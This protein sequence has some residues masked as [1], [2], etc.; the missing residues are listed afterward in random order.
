[1][2]RKELLGWASILLGV[3]FLGVAL[4]QL[5]QYISLN[6]MAGYARAQSLEKYQ[7]LQND[8]AQLD[9]LNT[10]LAANGNP[11]ITK[12]ELDAMG[13]QLL[14]QIDSSIQVINQQAN[15]LIP[16]FALDIVL[17]LVLLGAGVHMAGEKKRL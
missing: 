16:V 6:T 2:Y 1:M 12:A 11:S 14:S 15:S 17:G 13:P 10:Q 4:L 5:N 8:P 9:A 7:Q 3:A